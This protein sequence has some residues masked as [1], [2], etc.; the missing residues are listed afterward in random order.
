MRVGECGFEAVEGGADAAGNGFG[1]GLVLCGEAC[2][3]GAVEGGV[4]QFFGVDAGAVAVDDGGV[5]FAEK[6]ADHRAAGEGDAEGGWQLQS[7]EAQAGVF[8]VSGQT[9]RIAVP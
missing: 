2:G 9:Q 4:E 3:G 1:F 8:Q 5:V 7:I 6:C